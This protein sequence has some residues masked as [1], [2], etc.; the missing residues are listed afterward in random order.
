MKLLIVD[1]GSR[2]LAALKHQ[3]KGHSLTVVQFNCISS[4]RSFDAVIL[5]GGH[6]LSVVD[7]ENV[8][9]RELN[10][11]RKTKVPLLGICLGF[12]LICRAYG[13]EL[14]LLRAKE[15]GILQVKKIHNDKILASL[16]ATFKVFESHRWAVKKTKKLVALA[17]SSDGVEVIR[18]PKR[19]VYGVQFHP[20]KFV[21]KTQGAKILQNFLEIAKRS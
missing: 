16:P 14:Q 6:R 7:H 17:K 21:Y 12:E 19:L 5:S 18:L 15:R 2:F 9:R 1:N 13:E 3:L 20:E 11:I 10:L 8:Y 4:A